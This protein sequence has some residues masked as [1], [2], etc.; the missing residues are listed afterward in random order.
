MTSAIRHVTID[1]ADAYALADFWSQVLGLPLHEE[2]RPGDEEA[3]IEAARLLF[4]TVPEVKRGKNRLHFDLQPQDRTRD[5][6]VTRLLALGATLLDDQRTGDGMGWV[7][8]TD[9][10]GNEFC[11]ERSAAE[12]E[13]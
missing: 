3:Q 9:P 7:V 13:G 4:V 12:R 6:E 2:D 8:L 1:C 11:V 10:E 5:E